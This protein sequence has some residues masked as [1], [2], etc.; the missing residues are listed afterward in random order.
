MAYCAY[1]VSEPL[2]N[3][4]GSYAADAFLV[5]AGDPEVPP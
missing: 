2:L 4:V 5:Q 3:R 1:G